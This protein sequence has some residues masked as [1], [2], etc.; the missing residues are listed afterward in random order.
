MAKQ[1][2]IIQHWYGAPSY[3]EAARRNVNEGYHPEEYGT[4]FN[5][6][7]CKRVETALGYLRGWRDQANERGLQLLY[8]TLTR[9]DAHYEIIATPDGYH[10]GDVVASGMMKDL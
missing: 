5:R 8:R 7:G 6:V 2:F 3:I 4:D 10:E 9:P 1:T